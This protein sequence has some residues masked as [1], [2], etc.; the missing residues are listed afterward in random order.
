MS[1]GVINRVAIHE[2][3]A[4]GANSDILA[5][6]LVPSK[7]AAYRI[8]V[9]LAVGSIFNVMVGKTGNTTI[10]CALNSNTALTAGAT[11]TFSMG[12]D[13]DQTYNFQVETDGQIDL[14]QVDEVTGGVI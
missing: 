2:G 4:P 6:A 14:L 7:A 5:S 13:S 1:T 3:S 9:Q 12:V 10:A 8:T 11:Y